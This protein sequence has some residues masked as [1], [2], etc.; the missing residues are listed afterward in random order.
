MCMLYAFIVFHYF[1]LADILG[2]I[3]HFGPLKYVG[4]LQNKCREITVDD[5]Q[6]ITM[7][8]LQGVPKNQ[9][10]DKRFEGKCYNCGKKGHMEKDC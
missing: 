10:N 1:L 9:K 7:N 5:N 6:V 4:R 3:L 8:D 2:V